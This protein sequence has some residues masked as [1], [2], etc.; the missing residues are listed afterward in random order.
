MP[1]QDEQQESQGTSNL[2]LMA[3]A[4]SGEQK[5]YP[6]PSNFPERLMHV[7]ENDIATDC[8]WWLGEKGDTIA[9]HPGNIKKGSLLDAHFQGNRYTSFVR[10]LN[11]W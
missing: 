8:I 3:A 9:I 2:P 1:S 4:A 7:L 11:R 6:H 5:Y 10:N